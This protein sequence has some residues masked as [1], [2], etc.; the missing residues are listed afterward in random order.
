V[1]FCIPPTGSNRAAGPATA[2]AGTSKTE[3][4]RMTRSTGRVVPK[5]CRF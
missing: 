3:H 5:G 2:L 4:R 1:W